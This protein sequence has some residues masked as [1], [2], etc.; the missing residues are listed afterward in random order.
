VNDIERVS[1]IEEIRQL[2]SLYFRGVDTGDADL[3]RGLLAEDCELNYMGCCTDPKT[4]KDFI[5]AM[6]LVLRGRKSWS[7]DGMSKYG[8]VSVHQG[9]NFEVE[10]LS[11]TLA[12][13][14]WSMSDRLFFPPGGQYSTMTGYG[15]YHETYTKIGGAWKLKTTRI[16]R[17]RV[18]AA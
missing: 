8:I 11:D 7:S 6:N 4:G 14:I 2:K 17:I 18:E 12:K 15:H 3:V 10:F 13:V 9:H 16:T 5:P 1:A